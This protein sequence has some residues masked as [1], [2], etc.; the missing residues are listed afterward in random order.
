MSRCKQYVFLRVFFTFH[1]K[2]TQLKI[3]MSQEFE[4]QKITVHS[5]IK[6]SKHIAFWDTVLLTEFQVFFNRENAECKIYIFY[7]SIWGYY[8]AG[9]YD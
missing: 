3:I 9:L 8:D 5:S 4:V 7:F 6:Q 2:T 1:I